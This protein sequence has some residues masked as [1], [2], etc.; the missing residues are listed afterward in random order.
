MSLPK[1]KPTIYFKP[2]LIETVPIEQRLIH[3]LERWE[4]YKNWTSNGACRLVLAKCRKDIDDILN[5]NLDIFFALYDDGYHKKIADYCEVKPVELHANTVQL[6]N[7][8][9]ES[10]FKLSLY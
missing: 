8:N 5:E 1:N 4:Q 6:W 7:D 9:K 2:K 3:E 10:I